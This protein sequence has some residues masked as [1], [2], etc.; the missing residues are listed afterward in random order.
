[1]RGVRKQVA[2]AA[3]G[4]AAAP[5]IAGTESF[6]DESLATWHRGPQAGSPRDVACY[7]ISD[8]VVSGWGQVWIDDQLV[9][10]PEIMPPYAAQAL[11]IAAGGA[12]ALH[13]CASR[14]RR[15]IAAPCLIAIGPAP[16]T[17]GHFLIEML[18]RILVAR[19]AWPAKGRL[20]YRLLLDAATPDWLL[21]I[22]ADD[23]GISA[24]DVEMFRPWQE[25]VLLS[26]AILP[27]RVF[28]DHMMHPVAGRLIDELVERLRLPAGPDMPQRIFVARGMY[29]TPEADRR[30]CVN[31]Q[32]LIDLAVGRHGFVVIRP[33]RMKWQAQIALFRHAA[34]I[35]GLTGSGLHNALFCQQGS[36]VASI[37]L[38]NYVQSEIGALR[39]QPNGYLTRDIDLKKEFAVR[40]AIFDAFMRAVCA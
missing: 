7:L 36:R 37:G 16:R 31:E 32:E 17:Y 27:S 1:M 35:A 34:I 23:L 38:M 4:V 30:I 12:P 40:P 10:S 24:D 3:P 26:Q 5:L 25:Q 8:A 39:G 20:P 14:P 2:R 28:Q 29:H 33:E 11:D 21:R 15:T 19:E 9:T 18:F 13:Y 22:L 6:T